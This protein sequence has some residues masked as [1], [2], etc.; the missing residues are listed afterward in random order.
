MKMFFIPRYVTNT[1]VTFN[2]VKKIYY[3]T[4][5]SE[6]DSFLHHLRKKGKFRGG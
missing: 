3:L 5:L 2:L 4:V 6:E 1:E